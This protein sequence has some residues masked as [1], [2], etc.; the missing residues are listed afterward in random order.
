MLLALVTGCA[1]PLTQV[2]IVRH[3]EKA[4]TSADPDLSP[5]GQAR[6]QALAHVAAKAGVQAIFVTQFRRTQQTAQPLAQQLGLPMVQV[7]ASDTAGLV[8]RILARH[9]GQVVLVVAHSNTM[10]QIVSA[11]GGPA[12]EPIREA[13]YDNLLV[14][15][16]PPKGPVR[17]L[18]LRYGSPSEHPRP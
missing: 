18:H 13:D 15:L 9:A 16:R 14:V 17:L 2:L 10:A 6:A 3:A 8:Q 12:I 7:A 5:A 1:A 11:L 4:D